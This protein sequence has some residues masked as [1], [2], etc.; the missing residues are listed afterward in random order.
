M[1]EPTPTDLRR[2]FSRIAQAIPVKL[3]DGQR[4]HGAILRN[5]S[6]GGAFLAIEPPLHVGT[7]VSFPVHTPAGPIGLRGNVR[8]TR[9][10]P[11]PGGEPVG[12]GIAFAEVDADTL[13]LLAAWLSSEGT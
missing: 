12:I 2:R 9:S 11:G 5:V 10:L 7:G 1:P 8:W 6:L 4:T 13:D 3:F